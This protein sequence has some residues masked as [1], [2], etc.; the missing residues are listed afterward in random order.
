MRFFKK[1]QDWILKSEIEFGVYFLNGLIQDLSDRGA[2]KE[3]KNPL[4]PGKDSSVPLMHDDPS[5]LGLIGLA[6]F[7]K[8]KILFRI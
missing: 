1:I 2:P 5:C 6:K 7:T 3:P 4:R 8:R